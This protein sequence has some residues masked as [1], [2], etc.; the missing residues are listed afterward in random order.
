MT[1][2]VV[3][4]PRPLE[5]LNTKAVR[6]SSA[7][8]LFIASSS[9][10]KSCRGQ[11]QW[12]FKGAARHGSAQAAHLPSPLWDPPYPTASRLKSLAPCC[13]IQPGSFPS[14]PDRLKEPRVSVQH[15]L[16]DAPCPSKHPAPSLGTPP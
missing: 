10:S 9:R 1:M 13:W 8:A 5:Q 14:I 6:E 12:V 2:A 3:V 7:R 16:G 11:S 15:L 4:L